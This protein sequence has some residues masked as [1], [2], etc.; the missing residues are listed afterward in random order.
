MRTSPAR[1][2]GCVDVFS[3]AEIARAARVSTP[4]VVER[5][6]RS[7]PAGPPAYLPAREAIR[8]VRALSGAPEAGRDRE[9]LTTL[10]ARPRLRLLPL[11][12]SASIHLALLLALVLLSSSLF[13][14]EATERTVESPQPFHLVYLVA[15]GPGGGGGG[16]GRLQPAPPRRVQ[17]SAPTLIRTPRDPVRVVRRP[18]PRR[19][20]TPDPPKPADPPP[21][22]PPRVDPPQPEPPRRDPPEPPPGVHAPFAPDRSH[23]T[24]VPGAV[25]ARQTSTTTAGAGAGS[26]AGEGSGTGSGI[27][28]GA[29]LGPGLEAGF[30]G[31]PFRPGSDVEP[32]KLLR[33]VKPLYTDD[34]RKR[35]IQGAVLLEVVV[36]RDG[37]VGDI[38]IVRRLDPGLDD[39]AIQAV[40]QWRFSPARRQG[41]PVD[42]AVQISVAFSL[43]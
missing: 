39:R 30:G 24:D 15:T 5:L 7:Q 25:E 21:A 29:G 8:L 26:G 2:R 13:D 28:R 14:G 23:G 38:R 11:F 35:S 37:S 32:P 9:P 43:R 22:E 34:A 41:G 19:P 16:G 20:P 6:H 40:R 10:P 12:G 36:R 18:P 42:V 31:G 27:G 33:E 17:A 3:V 4:T 1:R